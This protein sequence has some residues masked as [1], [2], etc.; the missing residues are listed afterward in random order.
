MLTGG[1]TEVSY[2]EVNNRSV[3]NDPIRLLHQLVISRE[4]FYAQVSIAVQTRDSDLI[5]IGTLVCCLG[6]IISIEPQLAV[7][8]HFD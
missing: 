5:F 4:L 1:R 6:L 3:T 7:E 8:S 2:L